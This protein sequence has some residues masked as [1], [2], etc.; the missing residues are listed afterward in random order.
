M[1][2]KLSTLL[3]FVFLL[4]TACQKNVLYIGESESWTAKIDVMQSNDT[5]IQNFILKYQGEDLENVSG[6][7][8][9]YHIET[10]TGSSEGTGVLTNGGVLEGEAGN[11][12]GCALVQEDDEF[13]FTVEWDDKSESFSLKMN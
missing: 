9:K 4:L 10:D 12:S 6:N 7:K 11:C 2:K 5:E 3:L 13:V 8:I 1:I